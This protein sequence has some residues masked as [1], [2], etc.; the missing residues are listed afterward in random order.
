MNMKAVGW[1]LSTAAIAGL[2]LCLPN[3][4]WLRHSTIKITNQGASTVLRATMQAEK[5]TV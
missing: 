2:A 4:L 5:E 1:G 3:A